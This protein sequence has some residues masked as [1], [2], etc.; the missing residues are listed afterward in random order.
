MKS[1][2]KGA[3]KRAGQK[4]FP[5]AAPLSKTMPSAPRPKATQPASSAIFGGAK[6][7]G[8]DAFKKA[9]AKTPAKKAMGKAW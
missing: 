7:P 6:G 4:T 2:P 9:P 1:L 8:T 3:P 5:G